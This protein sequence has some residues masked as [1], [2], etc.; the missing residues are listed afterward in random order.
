M[1]DLGNVAILGG[2]GHLGSALAHLLTRTYEVS[3]KE[4]KIFY[5]KGSPAESVSDLCDLCMCDGNV[6]DKESVNETI[7]DCDTVFHMIGNTT[8]DPQKKMIQ[9]K[10][11][12][13]GTRNVLEATRS[14]QSVRK[15]IYTSTVNALGLPEPLGSIGDER[16]DPYN[17]A[18]KVHSFENSED[19]LNFIENANHAKDDRWVKRIG[20]GYFDSKLAAQELVQKYYREHGLPVIS[21]LPGTMFG[22]Y[23]YLIGNGM[24]IIKIYHNE[25]PGVLKGGLPLAHVLDVAQGHVQ[26]A[27]SNYYGEK[28]ICSGK[29]EDN[30]YLKD[31]VRIIAEVLREKD[32]SRK[33]RVP[34]KVFSKKMAMLGA[35]LSGIYSKIFGKPNILSVEAVVAGCMPS[36]YSS[37]K[38]SEMLGYEPK[39]SYREAV[40]EMFDYYKQKGLLNVKER[41]IDK[42]SCS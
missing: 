31:T 16:S 34:E 32:P 9:W 10:V 35:K 5:F 36:F 17:N 39:Y 15:L 11:N 18:N 8:F 3:P 30:R 25:M 21:I 38:A 28:F 22:P 27:Q 40:A 41:Y 26:A 37:K 1:R 33:I 6:L 42:K 29:P 4:V 23:D 2:T 14:S 24:Y 7:Q 19:A 12:V 13:E 20:I